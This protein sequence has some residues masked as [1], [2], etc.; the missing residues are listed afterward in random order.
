[1]TH[2][3]GILNITHDSFSD[4]GRFLDPDAAIRHG[5]A[6]HADGADYIDIGAE[7]THPDSQNVSADEEIRR[8]GPVIRG[9][10]AAN[11]PISVDTW[12]PEVMRFALAQ[13]AAIINDIAGLRD[14]AAVATISTHADARVIVMFNRAAG[15]R[16][17][18]IAADPEVILDEIDAFFAE[19]VA[20]LTRQGV[21]RERLILDPGMGMFLGVDPR[22]SLRVLARLASL[23]HHGLPLCISVSRKGF[24]GQVAAAGSTPRPVAQRGSATLAAELWA[25]LHGADFVR[26]HDVLALRAGLRTWNAIADER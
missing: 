16:A 15:P 26:T 5:I 7:S 1:M 3:L 23:R 9:L 20:T 11:V 14:E 22:V 25:A 6:L 17:E 24:L 19:R 12:K 18:R 8:L 10:R 2:I 21:A 4:G 13:G